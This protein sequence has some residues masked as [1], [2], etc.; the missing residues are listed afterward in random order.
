M[1]IDPSKVNLSEADIEEYLWRNPEALSVYRLHQVKRWLKRQ[2]RVP[3]GIID[4]LGI[5]DTG[6]PVVVEVKDDPL[7]SRDIA[8]I[9]RYAFDVHNI[10]RDRIRFTYPDGVFRVL[11]GP[12]IDHT[13]FRECEAVGVDVVQY[14]VTLNLSTMHMLWTEEFRQMRTEQWRVLR[15]D[16]ELDDDGWAYRANGHSDTATDGTE[17]SIADAVD[18]YLGRSADEGNDD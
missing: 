5:T 14:Q 1:I 4:L 13:T 11:V 2:Y 16:S 9:S 15:D 17:C 7:Q 12:S 3:S 10:L 18:D 8:Q 6:F